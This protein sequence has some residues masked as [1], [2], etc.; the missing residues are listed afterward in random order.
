MPRVRRRNAYQH[1]SEFDRGR[2]VAYRDCGLSYR[3]IAARV[4]RDPMTVSRIWNRWVHDSHTERRAGSQRP[5]ITNSREDRH[6]IRMALRDRTATSRTLSHEMGSF[7]RQQVSARTVRRRLQQ[8]GVSARRPWLRLPLTLQH[9]QERLQWCD[10]RR[11]WTQEWRHVV[12]SDESRFCIQHH[13]GRIRVWRHRGERTLPTCIRHRHT[14][15]SPGV[16]VWGAIGYTSRSPLVRIAGTLNSSRYISDVLGPV[17]LPYLRGLRNATFQQDNARPHVARTVLTFLDT[18]HVRL[19][20]WPARSPDL[21]P[22]ENVWSMVAKRLARHHSPVTTVDEL[23][24]SVEAAWT[25]VP[26]HA[27]QSL[28][29][30]MPRRITAVIAARG[31]CSG[32]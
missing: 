28:F 8:H 20:P 6:V 22:I 11:T 24:H 23:W 15:P 21:S 10:Q 17:A 31:G 14:G 5:P 19:L 1:V 32:Y 12:F 13:D 18:A 2:I 29:D 4:G 25:A 30:S 27:I 7:A 9:R 26:V 16:M 3:S